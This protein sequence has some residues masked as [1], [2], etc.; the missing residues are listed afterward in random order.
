MQQLLKDLQTA[1]ESGQSSYIV[2]LQ[3]QLEPM[4]KTPSEEILYNQ[5]IESI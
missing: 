5:L 3:E 1:I 2:Q 4:V